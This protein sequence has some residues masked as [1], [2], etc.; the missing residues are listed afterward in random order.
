MRTQRPVVADC[1]PGANSREHHPQIRCIGTGVVAVIAHISGTDPA[2]A[3][4]GA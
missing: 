4:F 1:G 2:V 3:R